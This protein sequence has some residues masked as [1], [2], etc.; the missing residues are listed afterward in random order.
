[1]S[2]LISWYT[3]S[4]EIELIVVA[5]E[6]VEVSKNQLKCGVFPIAFTESSITTVSTLILGSK[7]LELASMTTVISSGCFRSFL[8]RWSITDVAIISEISLLLED[9]FVLLVVEITL[10][11][12]FEIVDSV[13]FDVLLGSSDISSVVTPSTEIEL[14]VVALESVEVSKNQ[15]KCGVFPIAFTESSIPTV[16]KASDNLLTNSCLSMVFS[17]FCN[18]GTGTVNSKSKFNLIFAFRVSFSLVCSN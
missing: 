14:I 10:S 18:V 7:I 9:T 8:S 5:L 17:S 13:G 1:M 6:S 15:L 16:S 12:S 4:T 11:S 3:P 2:T